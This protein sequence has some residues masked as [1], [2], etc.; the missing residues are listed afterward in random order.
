MEN[1][2]ADFL[3]GKSKKKKNVLGKGK[4]LLLGNF[5]ECMKTN[6]ALK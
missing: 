6:A 2:I 4:I 1:L 5:P 3:L